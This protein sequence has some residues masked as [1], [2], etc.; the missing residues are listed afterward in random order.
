M[1]ILNIYGQ[2][3]EHTQAKIVG[4][5]E[6]LI[7]LKNA[8]ERALLDGKSKTSGAEGGLFA[9]LFAS[10]GEGYQVIVE[11]HN[12]TWGIDG[13]PGSFWNKP[14]SNPFYV[15]DAEYSS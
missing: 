8:I 15:A 2:Q 6:G 9:E 14:E 4:N 3:F 7:E 11:M 12:D 13:G 1:K 10:D 5:A